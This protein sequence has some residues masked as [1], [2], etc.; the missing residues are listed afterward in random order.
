VPLKNIQHRTG[1]K[2]GIRFKELQTAIL[3][4][5]QKTGASGGCPMQGRCQKVILGPATKCIADTRK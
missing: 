1:V 2:Y 3:Q 4:M 5:V